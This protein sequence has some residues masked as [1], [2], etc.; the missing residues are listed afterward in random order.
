LKDPSQLAAL[1][2]TGDVVRKSK[3][4]MA[5]RATQIAGRG[6]EDKTGVVEG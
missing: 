1:S 2:K 3:E 4:P 6:A 5:K